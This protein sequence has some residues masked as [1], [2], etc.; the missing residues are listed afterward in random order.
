MQSSPVAP[1]VSARRARAPTRSPRSH[2]RSEAFAR[3]LRNGRSWRFLPVAPLPALWRIALVAECPSRVPAHQ[4]AAPAHMSRFNFPLDQVSAPGE[5][6]PSAE[7][8]D[9]VD[10]QRRGR[11]PRPLPL[12]SRDSTRA[13]SW[14]ERLA[15]PSQPKSARR[16]GRGVARIASVR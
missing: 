16:K 3:R 15:R 10:A 14:K 6:G 12:I 4:N 7:A 5:V 1:R 9:P 8:R 11:K 2:T 13:R